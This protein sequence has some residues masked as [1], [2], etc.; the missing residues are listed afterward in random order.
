MRPPAEIKDWLTTEQMRQWA[1]EAPDEASGKRR[2]AIW[3]THNERMHAHE[4]A[5]SL[6]VSV[7]AVWLWIGQYNEDGPD[8]LLRTRR[9]GRRWGFMS[10]DEE[11]LFLKPFIGEAR[12]GTPPTPAEIRSAVEKHLNKDVSMSY[13]YR[14]LRRH[15]WAEIL[16]QSHQMKVSRRDAD[17]FGELARPWSRKR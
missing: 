13:V 16:A 15:G 14:L 1:G 9:G 7:Q 5:E 4:V 2:M 11:T 17:T 3:L 6:G 12:A 10:P 8:G